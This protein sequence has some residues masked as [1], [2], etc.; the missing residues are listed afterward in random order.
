MVP[1]P[2]SA[3]QYPLLNCPI[4][5]VNSLQI[6]NPVQ[7]LDPTTYS[8][9]LSMQTGTWASNAPLATPA[10]FV[11]ST[12]ANNMWT[13]GMV[14][15]GSMDNISFTTTPITYTPTITDY[16]FYVT[17]NVNCNFGN[18]YQPSIE[19]D[20]Q[21]L[22]REK[23]EIAAEAKAEELLLMC[24][25]EEQGKQYLEHGYFDVTTKSKKYRIRKG[26]SKN[27]EEL[28]EESKPKHVYC[29]HPAIWVPNQDNMLA[30]KLLLDTDEAAFLAK[31]NK[32]AL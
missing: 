3:E 24:I 10:P 6:C 19:N 11:W 31:A 1:M 30:Q 23:K 12:G 2:N 14:M 7:T 32:W 25:S 9:D 22:E 26:W 20:E 29:I 5:S 16:P 4:Q 28:D 13:G 21:R 15:L 18:A 8:Y 17:Y 27:I